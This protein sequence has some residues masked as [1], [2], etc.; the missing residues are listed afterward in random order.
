LI[1]N[2]CPNGFLFSEVKNLDFVL[3]IL[4]VINDT[5]LTATIKKLKAVPV[6]AAAFLLQPEKI[7]GIGNILVE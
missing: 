6:I 3:Q 7:K 4:G 1:S 5:A 2:R